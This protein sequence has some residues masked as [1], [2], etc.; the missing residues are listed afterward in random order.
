MNPTHS[1][2]LAALSVL[3]TAPLTAQCA[4]QWL[5]GS[6]PAGTDRAVAVTKLWDPDGAGPATPVYVVGGAFEYAGT[7]R[8]RGIAIWNPATS[9]WSD[10]AGGVSGVGINASVSAIEVLPS[11]ALL[12]GGNFTSAGAVAAP[13]L[14][15]WNGTAWTSFFGGTDGLVTALHVRP[16]GDVIVSGN[17]FHA[18]GVLAPFMAS[19]NGITWS[20]VGSGLDASANNLASLPNGDLMAAGVD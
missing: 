16:N 2:L 14:A 4:N 1:T 8:A 6:G 20:Q 19:W 7:V 13:N 3:V 15:V 5:P 18:G 10:L 9:T 12:V 11:G 17:F